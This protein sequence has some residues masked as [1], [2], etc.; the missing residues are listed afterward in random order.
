M[1]GDYC[2][3][4]LNTVLLAGV[5]NV[6]IDDGRRNEIDQFRGGVCTFD[7]LQKKSDGTANTVPQIGDRVDVNFY[8]A[9][10]A[11]RWMFRGKIADIDYY[12]NIA[13]INT[14]RITVTDAISDLG[15]AELSN[16]SIA[17]GLQSGAHV[18]A[19]MIGAGQS[20]YYANIQTGLSTLSGYT[21]TG[22]CLDQIN[23]VTTTEQGYIIAN[24]NGSIDWFQ[25]NTGY[26]APVYTFGFSEYLT[27]FRYDQVEVASAVS[28]R[29][30]YIVV[31]P[32]GLANAVSTAA[33]TGNK[34]SF[35]VST[36]D[37]TTT[38]AGYLADYLWGRYSN[39]D[40]DVQS[41]STTIEAQNITANKGLLS[42]LAVNNLVNVGFTASSSGYGVIIGRSISGTPSGTRFTY[43][44][45]GISLQP[46]LILNDTLVGKLDYGRL[47]F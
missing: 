5:L 11:E 33:V 8:V 35:A 29:F 7:Y 14:Y 43:Y 39:T 9:G 38:Q 31:Q 20:T 22:N 19:L 6:N 2:K 28:N 44:L 46:Y 17:G 10:D 41:V 32:D 16:L 26:A 12:Y 30:N 24:Q 40:A 36:L 13:Q 42:T 25:R 1:A 37:Q 47:S 3:V 15:Q 21:Y 4:Y 34:K 18:A 27:S 45:S 23:K